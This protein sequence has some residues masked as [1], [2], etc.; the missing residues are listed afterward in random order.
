MGINKILFIPIDLLAQAMQN[1][2]LPVAGTSSSPNPSHIQ[3]EEHC[4]PAEVQIV[5]PTPRAGP[6]RQGDRGTTTALDPQPSTSAQSD[7]VTVS[8]R[9]GLGTTSAT[10]GIEGHVLQIIEPRTDPEAWYNTARY[11]VVLV[12]DVDNELETVQIINNEE[13][14]GTS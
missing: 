3:D 7:A 6:T 11:Q 10:S 14:Q 9:H 13:G 4:P 2:D 12:Y 8:T 1:A 5:T